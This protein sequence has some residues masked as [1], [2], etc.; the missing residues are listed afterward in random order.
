[1]ELSTRTEGQVDID[2]DRVKG[3][4][5]AVQAQYVNAISNQMKRRNRQGRDFFTVRENKA[6]EFYGRASQQIDAI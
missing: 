2:T 3:P 5:E 6:I 4:F 1:M